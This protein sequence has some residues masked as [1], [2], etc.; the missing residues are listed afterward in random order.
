[1]SKKRIPRRKQL[2]TRDSEY[3]WTN[4]VL[5]VNLEFRVAI[6]EEGVDLTGSSDAGVD[7]SL[8]SLST[9]L[10]R[11]CEVAALE[12]SEVC[13]GI[14]LDVGDELQVVALLHELDELGLVDDFLAGCVDEHATLLHLAHECAV[15]ALLGL[16]G[17]WDV[18]RRNT[19]KIQSA[20]EGRAVEKTVGAVPLYCFTARCASRGRALQRAWRR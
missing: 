19:E 10:L 11:C 2:L 5:F 7:V 1:M 9:H 12:L 14:G 8:G 15:D 6:A 4:Q 3:E 13:V 18:E 17:G 16:S 20:G